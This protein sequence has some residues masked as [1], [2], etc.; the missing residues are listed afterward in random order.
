MG[1][2]GWVRKDLCWLFCGSTE[3]TFEEHK[4]R[5]SGKAALKDLLQRST[6]GQQPVRARNYL[7]LQQIFTCICYSMP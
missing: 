3:H 1:E 6:P 4:E 2:G 5:G 7:L